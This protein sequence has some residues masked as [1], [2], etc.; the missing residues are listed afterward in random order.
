MDTISERNLKLSASIRIILSFSGSTP[1]VSAQIRIGSVILASP[2]SQEAW[3]ASRT[4]TSWLVRTH[5]QFVKVTTISLMDTEKC[6]ITSVKVESTT[7]Q[8][9]SDAQ[10][11][12]DSFLSSAGSSG[13]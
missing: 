3:F 1:S 10:A 5:Q 7:L 4:R 12:G 11:V 2:E 8:S 9:T 6:L 13:G